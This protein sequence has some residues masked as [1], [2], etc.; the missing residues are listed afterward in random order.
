MPEFAIPQIEV[1]L[2]GFIRIVTLLY[3]MPVFSQSFVPVQFRIGLAF[4]LTVL[5]YDPM[6]AAAQIPEYA[7]IWSFAFIVSMEL[8][9]GLIV[10]FMFRALF[11][12]VSF[13]GRI[14]DMQ[15]GFAMLQMPDPVLEGQQNSSALGVFQI[16]FYT[17]VFLVANGHYYLF[18]ALEKSFELIPV[19]GLRIDGHTMY[20]IGVTTIVNTTEIALR[21]A[22]PLL[23]ILLITSMT[24][25]VIA[26]TMPQMNIFFVGM[27]LKLGVGF[28]SLIVI[29]PVLVSLFQK[30][31]MQLYRDIW[32]LM[33]QLAVV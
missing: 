2:L 11:A 4:F 1:F 8:V 14:I 9:L 12:A 32:Y 28:I 17:L 18:L 19:G 16:L 5:L 25:G 31:Y 21:L 15:L 24:L 20:E 30:L 3:L 7:T 6:F 27:P 29:F 23:S 22:L 13:G 26:K 33:Q 10:G